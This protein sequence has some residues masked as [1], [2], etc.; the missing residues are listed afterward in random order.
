MLPASQ[1][2]LYNANLAAHH[3]ALHY[4]SWKTIDAAVSIMQVL[5]GADV[6]VVVLDSAAKARC[7]LTERC[8]PDLKKL[9]DSA[10][11]LKVILPEACDC[12]TL[13]LMLIDN[14][15]IE[16]LAF[17][18]CFRQSVIKRLPCS[19]PAVRIQRLAERR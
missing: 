12:V 7:W 14:C 1:C 17:G 10:P 3:E 8:S 15:A 16:Q 11:F 19:P 4:I 9:F 2:H 18:L 6:I 5:Q 13:V